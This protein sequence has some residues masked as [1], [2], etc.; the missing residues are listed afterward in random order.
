MDPVGVQFAPIMSE[1]HYDLHGPL[2]SGYPFVQPNLWTNREDRSYVPPHQNNEHLLRSGNNVDNNENI[3]N[4]MDTREKEWENCSKEDIK[5]CDNTTSEQ[6]TQKQSQVAS[7]LKWLT[8]NYERAEGVCLPRCV[9]YTHYL[10]FCKK[11]KFTPAGAATFGKL[12]R[13]KFPKLTTRRLGTR[14]Q[15]KYHYYGIGIKETSIY[16]HSVYAGK[17]LTRFSGVKIKTEGSNRKYSLSS[18]TGT[19]LPEFPDASNLILEE[20]V[21]RDKLYTFILMYRTHCQRILDTVISA[22]F[23]EVQ[24]FLLHFWQGMPEHL[25]DI[26]KASMIADIIGLCDSILY[27]V[28]IDV[29]IPTT[30]QDLPESLAAELKMFVKKL[31]YWIENALEDSPEHLLNKKIEVTKGFIQSIKRQISFIQLAQTTRGVLMNHDLANQMIEDIAE[32]NFLEICCQAGFIEP[33]TTETFR[34]S[35]QDFFDEFQNLLTKQAPIEGYTEWLDTIIDTCVLQAGKSSK[36][37]FRDKAARFLLQ[38]TVF[39]SLFMRDMTLHSATSFGS[40]HLIRLMFDE[41]VFLV[42]ETQQQQSKDQVL[43]K[44]LKRIMK[45]AEE[46]KTQAKHRTPSSKLQHSPK[47]RKRKHSD[48]QYEST[49]EADIRGQDEHR[50]ILPNNNNYMPMAGTAFSRPVPSSIRDPCSLSF[51]EESCRGNVT[52]PSLSLSPLKHYTPF[53]SASFDR[54]TYLSQY[55]L[56]SY[57]DII[58]TGSS[59]TATRMQPYTDSHSQSFSHIPFSASMPQ[60]PSAYWTSDSRP[61]TYHDHYTPYSYNKL[62]TPYETLN[63]GSFLRGAAYQDVLNRAT[64]ESHRPYYRSH[65]DYNQV[66]GH[67]S[68]NGYNSTF[69]DIAQPSPQYGRQES[70]FYQDDLYSGTIGTPFSTMT[71][72][73]LTATFR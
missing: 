8:D 34:E 9:L 69:M 20:G 4:K 73:Y 54:P 43:Q 44:N 19:L 12:I 41:Y 16:Y 21:D 33:H 42:M 49:D 58:G 60:P 1:N 31:P 68:V 70:L 15:S 32:I 40:F 56:N 37:T 47:N 25:L 14:G 23:D 3:Q 53:N 2:S 7:T 26:L 65:H 10:D 72:P 51:A 11:V 39:S 48:E 13:Q 45:N 5:E 71:K 6:T 46:I 57:N 29:L 28:M 63:K 59:L 64:L 30:I 18:K 27:K 50:H 17:G 62:S 24:N 22:N 61:H 35:I 66:N 55:G 52:N 67:L 38:W 36:L